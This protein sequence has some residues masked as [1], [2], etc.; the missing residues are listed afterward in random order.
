MHQIDTEFT[1]AEMPP[2]QSAHSPGWFV[3]GG[4]GQRP[5]T[6]GA[7]YLNMVQAEFLNILAAGGLTPDKAKLNQISL[8]IRAIASSQSEESLELHIDDANPH[9]QYVL[10]TDYQQGIDD[11]I[12][13]HKAE[14]DPHDQYAKNDDVA[15]DISDAITNHKAEADPHDQYAKNDDVADDI[16]DAIAN[17]KA[18]DDAHSQYALASAV[19]SIATAAAASE[20]NKHKAENGAHSGAR[21][22]FDNA[23]TNIP[24]TD[25]EGA[26]K[27]VN[28]EAAANAQNILTLTETVANLSSASGQIQGETTPIFGE[29]PQVETEIPFSILINSTD[30]GVFRIDESENTIIFEQDTN[31]NFL[32]SA[33]LSFDTGNPR[34]VIFRIRRASDDLL[35]SERRL[36]IEESNNDKDQFISNNLVTVGK[37]GL[38][39]APLEV[40]LT[41]ECDGN[42]IEFTSF[43]SLIT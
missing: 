6:V 27:H 11:A 19:T 41:I 5:T 40:K 35:I 28:N 20:V 25:I 31:F 36:P 13:N 3:S 18:D 30:Q 32:T 37:N 16:S 39:S 15:D 17:H 21:I 9:S 26:V 2:F 24:A 23:G 8:A 12:T 14:A 10:A 29:I 38:P 7:D 43:D 42:D 22:S 1:A 34:E 33:F 4:A